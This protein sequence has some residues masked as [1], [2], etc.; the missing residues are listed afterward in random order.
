MRNVSGKSCKESQNTHFMSVTF[1]WNLYRLW[2][3]VEKYCRD[4]WTTGDTI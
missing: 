4:G 3:N 2:D 1:S